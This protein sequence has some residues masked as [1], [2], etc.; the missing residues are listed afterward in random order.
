MSIGHLAIGFGIFK[1][2]LN[3]SVRIIFQNVGKSKGFK[4]IPKDLSRRLDFMRDA[5][6][7]FPV[8]NTFKPSITHCVS[9][10]RGLADARNHVLHGSVIDYNKTTEVLTFLRLDVEKKARQPHVAVRLRIKVKNLAAKGDAAVA[11]SARMQ[12]V[13]ERLAKTFMP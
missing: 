13:M 10:A 5:A 3:T 7:Q 4:V 6:N 1:V 2:M 12:P 8:L 9:T 11:L